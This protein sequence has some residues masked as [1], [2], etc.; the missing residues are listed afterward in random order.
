MP[1]FDWNPQHDTRMCSGPATSDRGHVRRPSQVRGRGGEGVGLARKRSLPSASL[2][3][4]ASRRGA[5][6][7]RPHPRGSR[8]GRAGLLGSGVYA[9][10]LS[11]SLTACPVH[12]TISPRPHL[13]ERQHL[14]AGFFSCNET[15]I[16][17]LLVPAI[18]ALLPSFGNSKR[19][20]LADAHNACPPAP[21]DAH[22]ASLSA[23]HGTRAQLADARDACPPTQLMLMMLALYWELRE[24]AAG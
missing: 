11:G 12:A 4:S 18:S 21:A 14:P 3:F 1:T 16:I 22:D 24:S 23:G 15:S 10:R 20:E 6:G 5:Q 2:A 13:K 19:V 17:G 7:L 8:A 9:F